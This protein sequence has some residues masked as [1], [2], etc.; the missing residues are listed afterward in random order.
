MKTRAGGGPVKIPGPGGKRTSGKTKRPL[1]DLF[2]GVEYVQ[3]LV[4]GTEYGLLVPGDLSETGGEADLIPDGEGL[5][6]AHGNRGVH[7]VPQH[8]GGARRGGE[9]AGVRV[10][11]S[12]QVCPLNDGVEVNVDGRWGSV[13][14]QLRGTKGREKEKAKFFSGQN[15]SPFDLSGGDTPDENEGGEERA[16]LAVNADRRA[17]GC[18]FSLISKKTPRT[19]MVPAGDLA[20]MCISASKY[21]PLTRCSLGEWKWTPCTSNGS[22]WPAGTKEALGA[23]GSKAISREW[24]VLDSLEPGCATRSA[25]SGNVWASAEPSLMLM[26]DSYLSGAGELAVAGPEV[27]ARVALVA[28]IDLL[29]SLSEGEGPSEGGRSDQRKEE[30]GLQHDGVRK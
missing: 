19:E 11:A 13:E 14:W 23:A 28:E 17:F 8:A 29:L 18:G 1:H 7:N 26:G 10:E 6:D 30:D 12:E 5:R 22:V 27:R 16:T 15:L 20:T 24:P 9:G 4:R 25:G 3:A 2:Q 21:L